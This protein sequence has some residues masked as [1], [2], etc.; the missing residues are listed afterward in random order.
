MIPTPSPPACVRRI[1]RRQ[2]VLLSSVNAYA[3]GSNT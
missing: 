3:L 2:V 1:E